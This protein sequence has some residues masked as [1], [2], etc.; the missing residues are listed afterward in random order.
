METHEL[1]KLY[2][3]QAARQATE[4]VTRLS[5]YDRH[6]LADKIV[7]RIN[8][9]T[10]L[11]YGSSYLLISTIGEREPHTRLG[12]LIESIIREELWNRALREIN[13][14]LSNLDIDEDA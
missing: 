2:I 1:V 7:E 3:I 13:M 6:Q 9:G 5:D 8:P 11:Q 14:C 4:G 10:N 12:D